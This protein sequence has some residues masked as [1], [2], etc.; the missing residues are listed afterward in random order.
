MALTMEL[1]EALSDGERLCPAF[2]GLTPV[3]HGALPPTLQFK[4]AVAVTS[5]KDEISL[6]ATSAC[7]GT[8]SYLVSPLL[9]E[10][11]EQSDC[12]DRKH[13]TLGMT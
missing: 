4:A 7:A 1:Q 9:K 12:R 5:S 10:L 11:V 2:A 8:N 6:W 13:S 3:P